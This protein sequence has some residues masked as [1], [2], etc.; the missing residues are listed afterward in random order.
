MSVITCWCNFL[1][2]NWQDQEDWLCSC[3]WLIYK[4]FLER[5]LYEWGFFYYSTQRGARRPWISFL[6][7]EKAFVMTEWEYSFEVLRKFGTK[8][9][10]LNQSIFSALGAQSETQRR[11]LT[12]SSCLTNQM[13]GRAV[14]LTKHWDGQMIHHTIQGMICVDSLECEVSQWYI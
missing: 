6:E 10:I 12:S 4:K 11:N 2:K 8:G 3:Q 14:V 9:P 13:T 7:S 5:S 1:I